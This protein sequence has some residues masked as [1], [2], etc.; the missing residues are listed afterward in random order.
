MLHIG[1]VALA[2]AAFYV[3]AGDLLR[4]FA[5]PHG[6][7]QRARA[8]VAA[9]LLAL[10]AVAAVPVA[11]VSARGAAS[12]TGASPSCWNIASGFQ[13]SAPSITTASSSNVVTTAP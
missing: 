10:I 11:G 2:A 8:A 9:A 3:A 7:A 13:Y 4:V 1:L 5:P 12:G 6:A